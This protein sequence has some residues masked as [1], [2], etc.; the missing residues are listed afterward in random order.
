[1]MTFIFWRS[2]ARR[3]YIRS[4]AIASVGS[5]LWSL[6]FQQEYMNILLFILCSRGAA[7]VCPNA[8]PRPRLPLR[9]PPA[10]ASAKIIPALNV[11]LGGL[12]LRAATT[13]GLSS[14][15]L[16]YASTGLLAALNLAVTDN[17]RYASAKCAAGRVENPELPLAKLANQ[18][19]TAVRV[20]LLGQL[21]GLVWMVRANGPT[22]VLRGAA[23]FMAANVGF[24]LLGAGGAKHDA[25][26]LPAP[27]TPQLGKFVLIT[28][29]VLMGSAVAGACAPVGSTLRATFACLFAVG[30][31]IGAVEGVPKTV[32]ALKA[33]A[34]R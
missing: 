17:Q 9:A 30:C 33:L 4:P 20:Q 26:G 27:M 23:T 2:S 8:A 19:Y 34:R 24:F 16:V 10:F 18:W 31:L 28:D 11:G 3:N 22:G 5:G 1:M 21:I 6:D 14:T 32:I 13:S 7:F 25:N 29:I 15:T 12:L